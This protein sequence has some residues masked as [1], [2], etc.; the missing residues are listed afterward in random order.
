MAAVELTVGVETVLCDDY[1]VERAKMD[2]SFRCSILD[3]YVVGDEKAAC[4]CCLVELWHI[5]E[6]TVCVE[7]VP[8]RHLR[9]PSEH[10]QQSALREE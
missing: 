8:A 1:A 7:A 2:S 3:G 6:T 4:A 9:R 10:G 5:V